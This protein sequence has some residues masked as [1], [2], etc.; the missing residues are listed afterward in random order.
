MF[1]DML[2]NPYLPETL[3]S[4]AR[5]Y[6]LGVRTAK[7]STVKQ[8]T[9]RFKEKMRKAYEREKANG[10]LPKT[11]DG[12]DIKFV[13]WLKRQGLTNKAMADIVTAADTIS[14]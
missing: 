8:R 6:N 12:D 9:H 5:Q 1:N 7:D 14:V 2:A 11:K 3:D 10:N 13:T 4:I